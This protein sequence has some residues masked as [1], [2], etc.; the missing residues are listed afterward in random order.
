MILTS[1]QLKYYMEEVVRFQHYLKINFRIMITSAI[2]AGFFFLIAIG[3]NS[4]PIFEAMSG[5][6]LAVLIAS[7]IV[8]SN[9]CIDYDID[10]KSKDIFMQRCLDYEEYQA[11]KKETEE[12]LGYRKNENSSKINKI[13]K[14]KIIKAQ[15][16]LENDFLKALEDFYY[17]GL[18]QQENVI[19]SLKGD[20][21]IQDNLKSLFKRLHVGYDSRTLIQ[22]LQ[23]IKSKI[24]Y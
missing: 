4:F 14:I 23:C 18:E 19:L 3:L 10:T 21:K 9:K 20:Q 12:F 11:L 16:P 22:L 2:L 7:F 1:G 6:S 13:N 5:I 17:L 15:K 24:I 8:R